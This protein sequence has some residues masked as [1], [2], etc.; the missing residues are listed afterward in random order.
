M[1][2]RE[3]KALAAT[4]M[5][6]RD[7]RQLLTLIERN[8]KKGEGDVKGNW[9]KRGGNLY[10]RVIPGSGNQVYCYVQ[11]NT[12][13]TLGPASGERLM[14]IGEARKLIED[15]KVAVAKGVGAKAYLATRQ[16][17]EA[18]DA[19]KGVTVAMLV[20]EFCKAHEH[21]WKSRPH[22]RRWRTQTERIKKAIGQENVK[23][24]ANSLQAR[25]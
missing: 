21:K 15:I 1:E 16:A 10:V 19:T 12:R 8:A 23:G 3:L 20:D 22:I 25:A 6:I 13:L 11:G 4:G 5:T 18:E 14:P 7:A 2:R 17:K 24:V 9:I